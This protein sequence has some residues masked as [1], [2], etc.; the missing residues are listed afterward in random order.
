MKLSA[1]LL[2]SLLGMGLCACSSDNSVQGTTPPPTENAPQ[3]PGLPVV[4]DRAGLYKEI[5]VDLQINPSSALKPGDEVTFTYKVAVLEDG[6]HL[7]SARTD[8]DIGYNPTELTLFADESKGFEKLGDMTENA[9]ATEWQDPDLGLIRD[10]KE[11]EVTFTQKLKVTAE[12]AVLV[13]E[14]ATQYCREGMCKFAKFPVEW[15]LKR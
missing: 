11:K 9:T 5:D 10:F 2:V 3:N 15:A 4:D 13:G 1:F 14:F 7:Y 8:G 12:D 6:W